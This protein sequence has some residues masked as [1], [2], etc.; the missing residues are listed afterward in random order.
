MLSKPLAT[1]SVDLPLVEWALAAS[2]LG[3]VSN[4]PTGIDGR[5]ATSIAASLHDH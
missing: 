3:S 2:S 1:A 5:A 4:E